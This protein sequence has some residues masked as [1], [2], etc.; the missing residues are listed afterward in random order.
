[1][2]VSSARRRAEQ[3]FEECQEVLV[4]ESAC[5][6]VVDGRPAKEGEGEGEDGGKDGADELG[7]RVA[8]RVGV[9]RATSRRWRP[10]WQR[11]RAGA[12][13]GYGVAQKLEPLEGGHVVARV[14]LDPV[15]D[16]KPDV[17]Q[18]PGAETGVPERRGGAKRGETRSVGSEAA[19]STR[20]EETLSSTR[21]R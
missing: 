16:H 4:D 2:S 9:R 10:G 3:G 13:A 15:G 19:S 20:R 12:A 8:A 21:S 6:V 17:G 1:M 5:Q 14:V 7:R 18:S 11:H